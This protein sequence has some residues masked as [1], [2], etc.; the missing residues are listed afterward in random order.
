MKWLLHKIKHGNKGIV[1]QPFIPFGP[2][3]VE[4]DKRHVV[5]AVSVDDKMRD[6]YLSQTGDIVTPPAGLVLPGE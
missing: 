1:F 5:Y 3:K 2:S 6:A 4:V